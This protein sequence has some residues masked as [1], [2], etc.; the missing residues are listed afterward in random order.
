[1]VLLFEGISGFEF[2][3]LGVCFFF[4][5]RYLLEAPL[6]LQP[7]TKFLPPYFGPV[8]PALTTLRNPRIR[9]LADPLRNQP[10]VL[11]TSFSVHS[12]L[13]YRPLS[14]CSLRCELGVLLCPPCPA[15]YFHRLYASPLG[16]KTLLCATSPRHYPP[17]CRPFRSCRDSLCRFALIPPFFFSW[18]TKLIV[19][20]SPTV[21]Y[22][23]PR[24]HHPVAVFGP[25]KIQL[26]FPGVG[27]MFVLLPPFRT[28]IANT[29]PVS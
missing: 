29:I 27:G 14:G 12:F 21:V 9:I 8:P 10:S 16:V 24:Y 15:A 25:P 11:S 6:E 23:F 1:L 17:P 28:P 3:F 7:L 19:F 2:V 13:G 4:S 20:F 5:V 18:G 22:G 26:F